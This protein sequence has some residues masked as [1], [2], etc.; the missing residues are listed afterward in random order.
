MT[1]ARH[2]VINLSAVLPR[3][4]FQN[5][6]WRV[7]S[8]LRNLGTAFLIAVIALLSTG[9]QTLTIPAFDPSGNRIFA[10][11]P[12]QLTLPQLHGPTG[13]SI[14]PN[15]SYPEPQPPAHC[16]QGPQPVSPLAGV[17]QVAPNPPSTVPTADDVVR[18]C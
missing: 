6:A 1:A 12:T 13:T 2:D 10:S 7:V 9:C 4:G 5:A 8:Q 16:L 15:P 17:Q 3:T 18:C 11:T 14:V